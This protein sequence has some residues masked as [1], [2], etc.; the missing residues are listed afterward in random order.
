MKNSFIH[1]HVHSEY[2]LEDGLIRIA[3]LAKKTA[4][5][6]MPAIA[7]TEQGNLFSAIKFYRA[8][9]QH[10]IKPIIGID[11]RITEPTEQKNPSQLVL[12]CQNLQGYRNLNYLISR[13]YKER[14]QH[15]PPF[16]DKAWLQG[17]SEGL[18]ALSGAQQGEIGRALLAGKNKH[19][20]ELL[21]EWEQIFPNKFYLELHRTGDPLEEKYIAAA[22]AL[23]AENNIP[24][25]ATNNV[26][27]LIE[28]DFAAHE[29]RV[30]IQQSGILADPKRPK[31]YTKTQ[32]LRSSEE[33][34][35]LFS[36]IPSAIENTMMIA[37]RCNLE[38]ALGDNYL[39]EF[40]VPEGFD[41]NQWL[42][43]QS[44]ENLGGKLI[45]ED[46]ADI[47]AIQ[48]AYQDRL[49]LELKIIIQM[50]FAGYFLIVA[51]FVQWAK[52]N[53][54]AVGPGRGSGSGSLVAYVLG[55]TEIDPLRYDLLFERFLNLERVSLPDFDIDFCMENRDTVITYVAQKYGNDRVSQIITYGR[56]AARA[57]VRDV[58]R[59]LN[60]PYNFVD[61]LAKLIPIDISITLDRA[62]KEE[63]LLKQRY[64]EEPEV[65]TL[66]DLA[67]QLEGI[68]RNVGRH[69]GGII[70]SPKPLINYMPLYYEQGIDFPVSQFDMGDVEDIG[71][72]KFD[73]LGLRT[74]TIISSTVE[75]INKL[76][77]QE[78]G[79]E[80]AIVINNIPLDDAT[81]YTLICNNETTAIFQLESHGM[82]Q[83]IKR[84][85][86]KKFDDIIALIALFRPGPLQSGM[87]D[88]Y[89]DYQHGKTQ[90]KSTHPDI[91]S[92]LATTNGVV[93]YQ[94]Q[95]MKIAQILAGYTLGE[96]DLLRRAMGKKKLDEMAKQRLI[97]TE[98]AINKGVKQ[99]IARD[100][101]NIMEK[102]AGYGFNKSHSAAYALISYQTAWLKAHYPAYFMATVFSSDMDNQEKMIMLVEEIKFMQ[103]KLSPPSVNYSNYKFVVEKKDTIRFGLGAIK[104]VGVAAITEIIN[105][106]KNGFFSD[107]FNFCNR[108][109][110]RKVNKR[111]IESLIRSGATDDFGEDR[112]DTY[113]SMQKATQLAEQT[114]Y[115]NSSGQD[116][117]F[118]L[119]A[120]AH[121]NT[122][123]GS[124]LVNVAAWSDDER[125]NGEKRILGFYLQGHPILKYTQ[126]L[127]RLISNKLDKLKVANN[128]RIAGYID[129]MRSHSNNRLKFLELTLDDGTCYANIRIPADKQRKYND[130]ICKDTLIL[131][132]GDVIADD[133]FP[134][135]LVIVADKIYTLETIRKHAKILLTLSNE[136]DLDKKLNYLHTTLEPYRSGHSDFSIKY[137]NGTG[138]CTLHFSK[139]WKITINDI[140]LS[141]L[142]GYFGQENIHIDYPYH[143]HI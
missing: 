86:P 131:I 124:A 117:F 122:E 41:Q 135:G 106:R 70:I 39:P 84:L 74:L 112:S 130:S 93:L 71:L 94:E 62:M 37:Q 104:G 13:S 109:D 127:D 21:A 133:F 55:I 35:Q 44:Q 82:R 139:H 111:V 59:V 58:G 31:A 137:S 20:K 134:S 105:A 26:R 85:Q 34:M 19:A 23:A 140:L 47:D 75:D 4:T 57:V 63:A 36:D 142:R 53:N 97:F 22:I 29:A 116:D 28:E 45:V 54:I 67:K 78:R 6:N 136:N 81:P 11:I 77:A 33:M 95:V 42:R 88:E 107:I 64:Q 30:C 18:I 96:A 69:A 16:L 49:E 89:I 120:P 56:M 126:E 24:V 141:T 38:L 83:L 99:K 115:N 48:E 43:K 125:L 52:S 90:I 108:V 118:G 132:E 32:Y 119:S 14:Q 102:F 10:G 40:T 92:I 103:I 60:Y 114:N 73:F 113:A 66:I 138:Q 25:V 50:D 2:S 51:D 128:I 143:M 129:K 72:V 68:S 46:D 8:A 17:Y 110:M 123:N 98:K 79:S 5:H 12:L 61:E 65:T 80:E 1:L 91:D 76:T 3:E 15:C 87:V 100:I 7:L 9:Q 121:D 27:F 101:F